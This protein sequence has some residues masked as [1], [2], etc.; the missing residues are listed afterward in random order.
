MTDINWFDARDYVHWLS[1]ASGINY[2]LP[3]DREWKFLS[4][5]VVDQS[6]KNLFED[7]RLAW[8][9]EYASYGQRPPRK[10]RPVGAFGPNRLGIYDLN[11]NVWEWTDSCWLN[12]VNEDAEHERTEDCGG[13]RIIQGEHRSN[14][15]EYIRTAKAGGCSIGFPPSNFGMRI[16]RDPV[17][18]TPWVRRILSGFTIG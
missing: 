8:A 17:P 5:E 4:K 11:G 6:P 10:T 14:Q 12:G 3:T 7:P 13:V 15:S 9:N 1:K 16:V 18:T 2:R